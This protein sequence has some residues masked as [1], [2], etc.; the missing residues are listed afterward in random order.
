[1]RCS[2]FGGIPERGVLS[3]LSVPGVLSLLVQC[4]LVT[5]VSAVLV[6]AG[7]VECRVAFAFSGGECL[8]TGIQNLLNECISLL[9]GCFAKLFVVTAVEPAAAVDPGLF[10]ACEV[11]EGVAV[12]DDEVGV[13]SGFE[14]ADEVIDTELSGG[15]D[16]DEFESFFAGDTA[17]ANG[18]GGFLIE[19]SGE[20]PVVGIEGDD[21]TLLMH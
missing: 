20:F 16:G 9:A 15:V 11:G 2:G 19:V 3:I 18:F 17:I 21:D 14:G 8:F 1:M 7:P 5:E 6:L 12:P 13:F 10:A 4:G